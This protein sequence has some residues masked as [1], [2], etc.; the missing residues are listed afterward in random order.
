MIPGTRAGVWSA[1]TGVLCSMADALSAL[2]RSSAIDPAARVSGPRT[3][4][5]PPMPRTCRP[6]LP[7]AA[8]LALGLAAACQKGPAFGSDNAIIAV[9]DPDLDPAVEARVR[10]ALERE[11]Y[12]TRSERVFEVT[13]TTPATIGDFRKW[14]RLVVIESLPDAELVPD[15]AG[16]ADGEL[17]ARVED[18]WARDQTIWVI[19]AP[20]P[21]ATAELVDARIDSVYR[22]LHEGWVDHQMERMWASG[23]D[24]ASAERMLEELGFSLVVPEVYRPGTASA[25]P[26]TRTWYNEEPRRIVSLYWA[27]AAGSLS[28]ERVLEGR[29]TWGRLLFEGDEIEGALPGDSAAAGDSA[30]IDPDAP[31]DSVAPAAAP[32]QVSSTTLAGLPA[33]RLQGTWR[34]PSDLTGG[35]FLTYGV[36]CGD[37]L[38]LLDGNLYAPERDKYAFLLQFER[39]FETFRCEAGA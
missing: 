5:P 24:S 7:L 15:L 16:D 27:P 28:A 22:D 1:C 23:A 25:P 4:T 32:L 31:P 33:V 13:V 36:I 20:S 37:R 21:E 34:N 18:E 3:P 8:L 12:T 17:F 35:L 26:D 6:I 30:A 29:R 9:I 38:V 19:A 11:V 10:E 39:I 14:G 2:R